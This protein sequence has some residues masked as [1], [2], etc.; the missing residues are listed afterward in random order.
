M[1]LNST[2]PSLPSYY[3]SLFT[4]PTSMANRIEKLQQNFLWGGMGEDFKFHL[5]SWD[6]VCNLALIGRLGLEN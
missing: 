5:V 3:M 1:L 4:L 6:K 2:L